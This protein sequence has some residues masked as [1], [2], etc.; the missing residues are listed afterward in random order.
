MVVGRS[1]RK[2]SSLRRPAET[3]EPRC[4]RADVLPRAV[5]WS[6]SIRC[7]CWS[8]LRG[9]RACTASGTANRDGRAAWSVPDHRLV[10]LK[11]STTSAAGNDE[12]RRVVRFSSR[13][14]SS[15]SHPGIPAV[16]R[17]PYR[18][19][20][21][22]ETYESNVQETIN[23]KF[24]LIANRGQQYWRRPSRRPQHRQAL[25]NCQR[26]A[27]DE[28]ELRDHLRERRARSQTF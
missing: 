17:L 16:V 1:T 13:T 24:R 21:L 9:A 2:T 6:R 22:D 7:S 25:L 20:I 3:G 10:G 11:P 5:P 27:A 15:S 8:R 14:T 26:K 18:Y 23:A 28:R 12:Q 19:T 4:G